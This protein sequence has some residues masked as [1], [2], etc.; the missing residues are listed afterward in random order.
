MDLTK[1][2]LDEYKKK[3]KKKI[4]QTQIL[5]EKNASTG[6]VTHFYCLENNHP[7]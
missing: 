4:P 7:D 5:G 6:F 3:Q 1:G 2:L